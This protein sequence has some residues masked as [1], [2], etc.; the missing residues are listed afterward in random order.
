MGEVELVV[1]WHVSFQE[2]ERFV[3]EQAEWLERTLERKARQRLEVP[4]RRLVTGVKLP[5]FGREYE[6]EVCEEPG[7]KR[8]SFVEAGKKVKVRIGSQIEVKPTL[9]RWY[10]KKAREYF[11]GKVQDYGIRLGVHVQKVV[12]SSAR[13]Q[14]GSCMSEGRRV[15]L[16]WRLAL[17]PKEVANY[18]IAHEVAHLK[19]AEHSASFWELVAKVDRGYEKHRRWLRQQG[20][21]LVL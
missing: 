14:W 2:G 8:T 3:A 11:N 18:V 6:L 9:L 10:K 7:R 5:N 13:S 16:Q 15:S 21:T 1:P 20:H 17:A 19:V 12:V 4:R